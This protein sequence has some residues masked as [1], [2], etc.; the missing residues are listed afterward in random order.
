MLLLNRNSRYG[1][2]IFIDSGLLREAI[3]VF[4]RNSL[5]LPSY[6]ISGIEYYGIAHYVSNPIVY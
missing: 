6:V 3:P 4:S 2:F 1:I 5:R